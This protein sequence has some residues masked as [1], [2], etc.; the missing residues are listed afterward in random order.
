MV[1]R[2]LKREKEKIVFKFFNAVKDK[3]V[4]NMLDL[5]DDKYTIIEP[6]SIG[7]VTHGKDDLDHFFRTICFACDGVDFSLS[8]DEED[9]DFES[10][11]KC[12]FLLGESVTRHF[13]LKFQSFS[14][15]IVRFRNLKIK[16]LDMSFQ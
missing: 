14:S 2:A 3:D 15:D 12:E 13:R 16:E 11:R 7:H 5:F 8:F 1:V 6:F 9:K 10:R 4:K